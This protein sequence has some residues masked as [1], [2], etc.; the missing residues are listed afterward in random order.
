MEK[1]T[2]RRDDQGDLEPG[3]QRLFATEGDSWAKNPNRPDPANHN[4]ARDE[5]R[6]LSE[7]AQTLTNDLIGQKPTTDGTKEGDTGLK[8]RK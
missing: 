4:P 1:T 7:E 6:S 3:D 8:E 5:E 2:P